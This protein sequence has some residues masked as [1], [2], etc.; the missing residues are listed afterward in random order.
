MIFDYSVLSDNL[1]RKWFTE[2]TAA[3]T[4]VRNMIF[5]VTGVHDIT[6]ALTKLRQAI[7]DVIRLYDKD[8]VWYNNFIIDRIARHILK[9]I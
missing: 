7:E 2:K 6:L 4:V 8:L 5:K 9:I 3:E 1:F